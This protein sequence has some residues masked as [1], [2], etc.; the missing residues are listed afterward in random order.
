[1]AKKLWQPSDEQIKSTNMYRF[2]GV[3]NEKYNKQFTEYGALY[4]W[5]IENIPE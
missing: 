3:I 1:M 2:M 5:S 4:Q